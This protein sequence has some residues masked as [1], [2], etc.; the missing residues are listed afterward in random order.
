[1]TLNRR[2]GKVSDF[3][4]C[5]EICMSYL[6]HVWF[7][8]TYKKGIGGTQCG[9]Q[10]MQRVLKHADNKTFKFRKVDGMTLV[11]KYSLSLFI[12]APTSHLMCKNKKLK[13]N[14]KSRPFSFAVLS[15]LRGTNIQMLR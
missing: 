1:M 13:V 15:L 3:F 6:V 10:A 4:L 12:Y 14:L 8:A 2:P 11:Q 7:D 9:H 5:N